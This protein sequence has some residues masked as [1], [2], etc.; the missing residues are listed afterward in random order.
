LRVRGKEPKQAVNNHKIGVR[1]SLGLSAGYI[2]VANARLMASIIV[3]VL[4]YGLAYIYRGL[5]EP[6]DAELRPR[7]VLLFAAN[8]LS[9]TLLTSEITAFWYLR[10]VSSDTSFVREMM[11]SIT[12]AVYATALIVVGIRKR[13]APIRYF[14]IVVFAGTILKVVVVDMAEL[15]QIYRVSSIVGL[16]VMLLVT[17]YLYNRFSAKLAGPLDAQR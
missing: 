4:L 13:Y 14:A 16:G 5:K 9:L 10:G 15:E 17:S 2:V 12:W 3:V 7:T 11:L 1:E 6:L 8:V